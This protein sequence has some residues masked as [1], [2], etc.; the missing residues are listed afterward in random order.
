M[1]GPDA[2]A[3]SVARARQLVFFLLLRSLL[4]RP[5]RMSARARCAMLFTPQLGRVDHKSA[6]SSSLARARQVSA[7][8]RQALL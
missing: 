8:A 6:S 7:R 1:L 3:L 5:R 4:A 2:G